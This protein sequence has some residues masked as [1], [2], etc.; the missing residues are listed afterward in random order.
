MTTVALGD[1]DAFVSEVH[2]HPPFPWQRRLV[3][4]IAETGWPPAID[5]PT[6]LGKTSVIDAFVFAAALAPEATPRRLFF[7]IDR[8]IVVDEAFE[9]ATA[10]AA[11]LA[12]PRGVVCRSVADRLHLPDDGQ[13]G[14]AAQPLG[15]T[16]MRGGVTWDWRWLDRPDR[17]A[18]VVGTVDQIGS[19]LLF[20][21][22]GV[23]ERLRPIDAALVGCDS[24][25]V[26][27]EAHLSRP[28]LE[29]AAEAQRL[30]GGDVGKPPVVVTM[31]AT[32]DAAVNDVVRID[33]ADAADPVAGRRLTAAKRVYGVEVAT[34]VRQ[35]EPTVAAALAE[36][37]LRIV[38]DAD[39]RQVVGI[40][41]NT[42][43]R[44]RAV[45][46]VL[47]G[48]DAEA[49]LLTG[50]IRPVDRDALLDRWYERIRAGR[51]R[52][53][54]GP[55]FVVA[56]QTIEVGA[57]VD[58]D[59]LVTESASLPALVQRLGRLN[60]L[61]SAP[62]EAPCV[63]VHDGSV[64]DEDH[65]YGS[66][67][68]ATWQWLTGRIAPVAHAPRG[69]SL[70]DLSH[71]MA[72][73]PGALA[74]LVRDLD[75]D[76]REQLAGGSSY[77][78]VLFE[79][80]LD[81]WVR[82]A[83]VPVPDTPVAPFLH[84]I[85]R[86]VPEVGL[87]WRAGLPPLTQETEEFWG[88]ALD[89]VPPVADETLE[90]TLAAARRWLAQPKASPYPVSDVGPQGPIEPDVV[91]PSDRRLVLRYRG[92]GDV[93]AVPYAAL[94]PGDTVVLRAEDGGCDAFG[95]HPESGRPVID[96]ADV[97]MRRG[98]PLVRLRPYLVEVVVPA[99]DLELREHIEL[100]LAA[101]DDLRAADD[102]DDDD[103]RTA[104]KARLVAAVTQ[105]PDGDKESVLSRALR[106]LAE[107][108][109]VQ[110]TTAG[111]RYTDLLLGVA[112]APLGEDSTALGSSLGTPGRRVTLAGHQRAVGDRAGTF[113][114][115]LG[116][117]DALVR[118]VVA[119]AQWHDEGKRDP[120]FQA[121]LHN[122]DSLAAEVAAEPLAKSG[123][124]GL[125]RRAFRLAQVRSG[126]PGRMRHEALSAR[127]A[128]LYLAERD[129]V[130]A[131]LVRHLV[132]SH[133]G[134]SRPLLPPVT[135]DSPVDVVIE[136]VDGAVVLRTD[137]C[138]DWE[139]PA[140][141]VALNARYGRWGLALLEAI[142]RLADIHCSET[143][144]GDE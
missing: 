136:T 108:P 116:L 41:A 94:A 14:N 137:E 110:R 113:A 13:F 27:D 66:A 84:G 52:G 34:T 88:D 32:P 30:D 7:V 107:R 121:M 59:G 9:H 133:H 51:A 68:Q 122:G 10:V 118:A 91:E 86:V 36:W 25:I 98:K 33:E 72:A 61:G 143:G 79:S 26:V 71:G 103:A 131:D 4:R 42:V 138:V 47:R 74:T 80:T 95:W 21:G 8:R 111:S 82:T 2:D 112:R 83:P 119:A 48:R 135:D 134:R 58:F 64:T 93:R 124:N 97:A 44:A 39:V 120:R 128:A 73:S 130:D 70:A 63:V 60:R 20:R 11:A 38:A 105:L 114:R 3:R 96:V 144:E 77:V 5:V 65:V 99:F 29:T 19:R 126:Y 125:D 76:R 37:A 40:V 28:F 54:D 49:I 100:I 102:A 22:Y 85:D 16:R 46:E 115:N 101:A 56:T 35:A 62:V 69:Q 129:D 31:S 12:E 57:N 104:A 87:V 140:R 15:V 78:P 123:M 17:R 43:S 50:R 90:V 55:L 106:R 81:T 6:G 75:P 117:D 127:A 53:T 18:I 142:V 1:F 92:V 24:V 45:L 89:A 139:Q 141:F 67:R 23:G 132:A 109:V